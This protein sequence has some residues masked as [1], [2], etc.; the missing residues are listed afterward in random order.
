MA[1]ELTTGLFVT[2]EGPEG[3]GKSTHSKRLYKE[4]VDDGYDVV[5][6]FEPGGTELG[7]R[8]RELLLKMDAVR[9][10]NMTELFLFEA[11]RAQHVRE[12]IKPS[13]EA[14][15]VVLCDRFNTATFA[16]QGYGLGMCMDMIKKLDALATDGVNPDLT[17]LL[18]V[19]VAIGMV[20]AK[21]RGAVDRME[22]R[23]LEFHENVRRG[24]LALASEEPGKIRVMSSDDDIELVYDSVKKE[25]YDLIER[26]KRAG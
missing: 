12:M 10:D 25:V 11:D 4:L 3:S 14:N 1:K 24:Y 26:H 13:L 23:E 15:K 20:R 8:V 17:I 22:K 19:E 5:R 6:T 16:Y 9:L 7:Q 18:D 21:A 2:F